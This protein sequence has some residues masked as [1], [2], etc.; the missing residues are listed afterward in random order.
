MI[1]FLKNNAMKIFKLVPLFAI[2][3]L[4]SCSSVRV[5]TDYDREANFNDFGSFA[6]FKPGIDKAKI[7]D[8][9]KRRV[10][11]AIDG[12]LSAK[13]MVKSET[14][15][16]L[17]SICTKESERVDVY[18]NNFG[19][20]RGA[21]GWGT[22]FGWGGNWGNTV[23]KSTEGTLYIDLIDAK[24]QELVWQGVGRSSLYRGSNID[25]KEE[26]IKCIVSEILMEYPP[27]QVK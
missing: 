23:S 16:L 14:P 19:W 4:A 21:W 5:T 6:F 8:L 24:T 11:R 1:H 17:I 25:K 10:L 22:G 2:L 27:N 13:G 7:S 18:N 26:K 20:G 9:D 3:V 12:E 15:D